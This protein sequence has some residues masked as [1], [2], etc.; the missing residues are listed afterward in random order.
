M[1]IRI[2]HVTGL[3]GLGSG[4]PFPNQPL[5]DCRSVEPLA[6]W[7]RE[8][9]API[10]AATFSSPLTAVRTGLGYECRNRN[11]EETGKISAHAIGLALDIFGFELANGKIVSVGSK[12]NP[13]SEAAL[14]TIRIA[15][16]GWF[17]TILGPGS[18]AA[19]A[20]HLHVDVLQHGSDS[21]YRICE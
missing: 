14:R 9:V 3:H 13:V 6:R 11:Q 1:P 20:N 7:L 10:F 19:H 17:T 16:C 12:N 15:G 21:R 4:I 8:V 2:K 5:I 18:D